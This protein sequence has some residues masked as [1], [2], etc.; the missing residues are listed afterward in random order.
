MYSIASGVI[1]FFSLLVTSFPVPLLVDGADADEVT[2]A[3]GD[4]TASTA[5]PTSCV[6]VGTKAGSDL[7]APRRRSDWIGSNA[8]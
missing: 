3:A 1:L 6:A 8:G 5:L 2:G 4:A 7:L